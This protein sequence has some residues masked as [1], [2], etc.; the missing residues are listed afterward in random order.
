MHSYVSELLIFRYIELECQIGNRL[1]LARRDVLPEMQSN[2]QR[3]QDVEDLKKQLAS[4]QDMAAKGQQV[5][6][7]LCFPGMADDNSTSI[8]S[9][10][11]PSEILGHIFWNISFPGANHP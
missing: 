11:R 4:A 6:K 3:R 7:Y 2:R 1:R 10:G 8:E 9:S 5:K